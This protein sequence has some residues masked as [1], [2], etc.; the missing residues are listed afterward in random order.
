MS[1]KEY[2]KHQINW[3]FLPGVN[4]LLPT[5]ILFTVIVLL[6]NLVFS[7]FLL[8]IHMDAGK[9]S[10]SFEYLRSDESSQDFWY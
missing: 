5:E 1:T 6:L 4:L 10:V 2:S 9:L 8:F 3:A 7:L